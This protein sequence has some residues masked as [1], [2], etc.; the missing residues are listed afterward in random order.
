MAG[1]VVI[2][3]MFLLL[4]ARKLRWRT[5]GP[6]RVLCGPLCGMCRQMSSNSIGTLDEHC[7]DQ[8]NALPG[9]M[10]ANTVDP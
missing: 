2:N 8:R 4:K 10:A 6:L 1:I 5:G 3:K 7:M 9:I